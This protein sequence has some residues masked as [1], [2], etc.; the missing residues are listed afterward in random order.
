MH[1]EVELPPPAAAVS[2]GSARARQSAA[3]RGVPMV[4]NVCRW[5]R[6]GDGARGGGYAARMDRRPTAKHRARRRLLA[7][8]GIGARKRVIRT[9]RGRG[10]FA[11]AHRLVADGRAR[12][13]R[14]EL[15][16]CRGGQG[17]ARCD[18][19]STLRTHR[20]PPSRQLGEAAAVRQADRRCGQ[21]A[22]VAVPPLREDRRARY[23]A[24]AISTTYVHPHMGWSSVQIS[25]SVRASTRERRRGSRGSHADGRAAPDVLATNQ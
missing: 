4:A 3:P 10:R 8:G 23:R 20:A 21:E 18:V 7:L 2:G 15:R 13:R 16:R 25:R 14:L 22:R 11:A 24:R 5:P 9:P 17:R 6:T 12:A 19:R 1:E